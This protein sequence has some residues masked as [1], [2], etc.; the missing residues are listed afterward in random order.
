MVDVVLSFTQ[1]A[2]ELIVAL[3]EKLERFA[4][5]VG[6]ICINE[7]GVSVQV[8]PDLLVQANLKGCSLWL[9]RWCF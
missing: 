2:F 4:G 8:V 9:L 1:P 5:N 3:E 7:L 6:R